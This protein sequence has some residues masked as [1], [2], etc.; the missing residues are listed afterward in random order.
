MFNPSQYNFPDETD[1]K[2]IRNYSPEVRE[3]TP[4]VNV[5]PKL[6]IPIN[7]RL[8]VL[9]Q[10]EIEHK[11]NHKPE[12]MLSPSVQPSTKVSSPVVNPFETPITIKGTPTAGGRSQKK[13]QNLLK[14][15]YQSAYKTFGFLHSLDRTL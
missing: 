3:T 13:V 6:L 7:R 8:G 5:N 2:N 15:P 1:I 12:V 9:K 11:I 10:I 14:D 4:P